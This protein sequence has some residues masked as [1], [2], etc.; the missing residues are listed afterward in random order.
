MLDAARHVADV[1]LHF[2]FSGQKVPL[3]PFR[4]NLVCVCRRVDRER[5]APATKRTPHHAQRGQQKY[6]RS[7]ATASEEAG[8]VASSVPSAASPDPKKREVACPL[9]V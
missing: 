7:A 9:V 5:R 8:P 4:E 2:I 6:E 1:L 3:V